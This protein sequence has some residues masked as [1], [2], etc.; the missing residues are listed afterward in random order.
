MS[1]ITSSK[2]IICPQEWGLVVSD[3]KPGTVEPTSGLLDESRVA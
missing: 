2:T 3:I 1:A